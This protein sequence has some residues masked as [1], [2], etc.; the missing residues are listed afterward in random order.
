S[1]DD[2]ENLIGADHTVRRGLVDSRRAGRVQNNS[3]QRTNAVGRNVD[4]A[5]D[6][7]IDQFGTQDLFDR[8][9]HPGPRLPGPDDGDFS[10]LRNVQFATADRQQVTA[11]L[12]RIAHEPLSP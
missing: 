2:L 3:S 6:K 11:E 8:G 1:I 7:A 9:R 12:Y 4:P 5:D 10:Q